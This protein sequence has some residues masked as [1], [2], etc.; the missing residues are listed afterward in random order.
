MA[1]A[2]VGLAGFLR[3]TLATSPDTAR[4]VSAAILVPLTLVPTL[5]GHE[6]FVGFLMGIAAAAA[7][8]LSALQA[9]AG[10]SAVPVVAVLLAALLP[11]GAALQVF[12][13]GWLLLGAAAGVALFVIGYAARER[14]RLGGWALTLAAGLYP[15]VLLAPAIALRERA[16]GLGLILL[17][18]AATWACDTAAFFVGRRWGKHRLAP[19]VSPGKTVEGVAGGLVGGLIVGAI[20]SFLVPEAPARVLGLGIIVAAAAILGDLAESAMKRRLG[21]KD[22]GW[23]VPGHGGLLDRID[24][25]LFGSFLGYLFIAITDGVFRA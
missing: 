5:L 12:T 2:N 15:G 16:D 1:A 13:P 19:A 6:W 22:S 23:L 20:A 14:S 25:L 9:R 8:E 18:M 11:L 24:G 10:V 17:I 21:A 3:K 4:F 7:W